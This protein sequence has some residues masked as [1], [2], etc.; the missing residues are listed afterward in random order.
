MS[1]RAG[2]VHAARRG[3]HRRRSRRLWAAH[4]AVP[5][6]LGSTVA[7][8]AVVAPI[9]ASHLRVDA[10]PGTSALG[11]A[12]ED[13]AVRDAS[14]SAAPVTVVPVA[15][16]RRADGT[17]QPAPTGTP[18]S[19]LT[20]PTGVSATTLAPAHPS[21]TKTSRGKQRGRWSR[22]PT[23]PP[24]ETD[25]GGPPV[26]VPTAIPTSLPPLPS[27]SPSPQ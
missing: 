14:E 9:A 1:S 21:D 11:A 16:E 22:E 15:D 10:R 3:R 4:H 23:S 19:A 7:A 8:A 2:P 24:E 18:P 25:D 27:L 12:G 20:A 6:A 17:S 13:R 26:L 5:I